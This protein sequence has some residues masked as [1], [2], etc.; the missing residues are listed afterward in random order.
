M[1]VFEKQLQ[2]AAVESVQRSSKEIK[3]GVN[4]LDSIAATEHH[5]LWGDNVCWVVDRLKGQARDG[6]DSM[7]FAGAKDKER[8]A[9]SESLVDLSNACSLVKDSA[10]L[11]TPSSQ[12]SFVAKNI[13]V[14]KS[15]CH[16]LTDQFDDFTLTMKDA[17]LERATAKAKNHHRHVHNPSLSGV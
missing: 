2:R 5:P 1:S 17:D 11:P 7:S 16:H 15:I 6:V 8:E 13:G 3:R 4:A 14:V 9:V 12:V 10:V